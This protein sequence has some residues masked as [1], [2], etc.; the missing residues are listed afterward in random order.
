V[1]ST[2][3]DVVPATS[4][5]CAGCEDVSATGSAAGGPAL[6]VLEP[7]RVGGIVAPADGADGAVRGAAVR[8]ACRPYCGRP[9][10]T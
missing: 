1:G 7:C 10:Q 8:V 5:D 2:G 9:D 6:R 4:E 3:E